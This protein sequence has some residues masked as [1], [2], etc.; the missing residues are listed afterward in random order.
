MFCRIFSACSRILF[1]LTL[2]TFVGTGKMVNAGWLYALADEGDGNEIYGFEVN[3]TTGELTALPGFPVS[4]GGLG[5]DVALICHRMVADAANNRLYVINN[6]S[7]SV[8][9]FMVDPATG[10]LTAMP[11]SPIAIGTGTW[12]AMDVHPSG[13]PLIVSNGATGGGAVSIN[14]T[15]TTATIAAG[16]PFLFGAATAFSNTFSADGS[17]YYVGGNT[18]GNIAGFSV[19]TSTGVLSPLKGSP[20]A[21]GANNPVAHATDS[22]GRLFLLNTGSTANP[23][24]IR[25][26]T[27]TD[28]IPT[29]VTNNPFLSGLS[30]RRDSLIH[31]NENF[32]IVAGNTGNNIGVYAI[33]GTGADTMLAAVAGSPFPGGGTTANVLAITPDGNFLYLGNR[34]SRNISTFAFNTS[35]G[36]LTNLGVQPSNTIGSVG[37]VTGMA[38]LPAGFAFASIAGRIATA[39]GVGVSNAVVRLVSMDGTTTLVA[40]TSPFGYYSFPSVQ[41]GRT[42]TLTPSR[43]GYVF[44]PTSIVHDHTADVGDLDFT[45]SRDK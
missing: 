15:D 8:S 39:G 44:S 13:S 18:G 38:Y 10:A 43:K 2:I 6:T 14:I 19:N 4:T 34:L 23:P 17:F 37:S 7:N 27:T 28:G 11:F 20:F 35:T 32:F 36:D 45:G 9:A 16:S 3:E 33:S 26:F 12:N 25:V 30:Q 5:N 41:T 24:P 29:G 1:V 40:R 21:T 22:Q 42:Y 31:P